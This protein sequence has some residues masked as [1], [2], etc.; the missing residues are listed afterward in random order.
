[1]Y[2]YQLTQS[3]YGGTKE[4]GKTMIRI[5]EKDVV[6]KEK[7]TI[8]LLRIFGVGILAQFRL[9]DE[10]WRESEVPSFPGSLPWFCNEAQGMD[11]LN[12]KKETVLDT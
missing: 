5:D 8:P 11:K 10:L 2:P 7:K 4:E 1:M 12:R 6:K 3:H 9:S